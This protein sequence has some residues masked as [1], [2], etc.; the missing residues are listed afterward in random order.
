MIHRH[1]STFHVQRVPR[2]FIVSQILC[3]DSRFLLPRM[4]PPS[5][6]AFQIVTTGTLLSGNH[7]SSTILYIAFVELLNKVFVI[8]WFQRQVKC[9]HRGA[10]AKLFKKKDTSC[11]ISSSWTRSTLPNLYL[12]CLV[13][14]I[15]LYRCTKRNGKAVNLRKAIL[16]SSRFKFL[17]VHSSV[18]NGQ[19]L[20]F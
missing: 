3:E 12:L 6:D 11:Q 20:I 9:Q 8:S 17:L 16:G 13:T 19:V 5:G 2:Q 1:R 10:M 7:H 15:K 14:L 18:K 4:R